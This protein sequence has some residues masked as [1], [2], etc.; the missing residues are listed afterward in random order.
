MPTVINSVNN[1]GFIHIPKTSGIFYS[2]YLC[3]K[4]SNNKIYYKKIVSI[5]SYHLAAFEFE[6]DNYELTCIIRNPYDR[7]ISAFLM[8]RTF[9][10]YPGTT[11]GLDDAIDNNFLDITNSN[12]KENFI[13]F[14]RPMVY[15]T[16]T[17]DLKKILVKNI[18]RFEDIIKE[19]FYK[20]DG[21]NNNHHFVLSD[22]AIKFINELYEQDFKE[23]NY[24]HKNIILLN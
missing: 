9:H 21:Y 1:T 2:D 10:T 20:N 6:N 23:F 15:F 8:T 7:F 24:D 17:K 12:H 11:H 19:D 4:D 5:Y 3:N 13:C 22:K 14:F 18:I 16:H